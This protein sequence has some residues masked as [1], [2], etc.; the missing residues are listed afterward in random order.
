[1][2][3]ASACDVLQWS[4]I[5]DFF[6]F[7]LDGLAVDTQVLRR[8]RGIVD[9]ERLLR[10]CLLYGLPHASIAGTAAEARRLNLGFLS[11]P[12]L[13]RWISRAEPFLQSVFKY[14]LGIACDRREAWEGERLVG[15][16]ASVLCGPG[17][18]GT[19]QRLHVAYDL[20]SGR[21]IHVEVTDAKGG[22]TFRRYLGLGPGHLVLAD[23]GYGHGP[24][25]VPLLESG[26]SVL[27]RINFYNIRLLN[28]EGAKITPEMAESLLPSEGTVEFA[29]ILPGRAEPVRLFGA[30]NDEGEGV[31]LLSNLPE[32]KLKKEQVRELYARRWQIELFFKRIKTVL[33][34]DQLPTRD[35]P[36]ARA[37]MWI[38]LILAMLAALVGSELFPP[39]DLAE[40]RRDEIAPLETVPAVAKRGR[41]RKP[42][43]GRR[44]G[45]ALRPNAAR[46]SRQKENHAV[47][48]G[49]ESLERVHCGDALFRQNLDGTAPR[50]E[51]E[52]TPERSEKRTANGPQTVEIMEMQQLAL[53]IL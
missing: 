26:T 10:I 1:M 42:L 23:Q 44:A 43:A 18:K 40:R 48:T 30:R 17:A 16:D 36:T 51:A 27:V 52:G 38:K 13:F 20:G 39:W 34:A 7:D 33:D 22:E 11:G 29:A 6:P 9:G 25:I 4:S 3:A 2:A 19:D 12:A 24:G 35:G 45:K 21:T 5:R 28:L 49:A 32:S 8:R 31:W 41:P 47:S 14:M 46:E 50:K 37:W 53:E 15:V